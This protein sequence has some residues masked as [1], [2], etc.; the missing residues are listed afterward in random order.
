MRLTSLQGGLIVAA[1]FV[2]SG[3]L[4]VLG[5]VQLQSPSGSYESNVALFNAAVERWAALTAESP[6]GNRSFQVVQSGDSTGALTHQQG[7]RGATEAHAKDLQPWNESFWVGTVTVS[8][9]EE[10]PWFRLTVGSDPPQAIDFQ[11]L[12]AFAHGFPQPPDG[13]GQGCIRRERTSEPAPETFR[14]A[15][16]RLPKRLGRLL[17]VTNAIEA[18]TW[19]Q[20]DGGWA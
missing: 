12:A 15:V 18:G 14:Q 11:V 16:G 20:Q 13:G 19:R 7:Q 2:V 10:L 1:L 5:I 4:L 3:V 17:S 8:R 9:G 6:T